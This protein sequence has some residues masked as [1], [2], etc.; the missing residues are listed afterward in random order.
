MIENNIAH[1]IGNVSDET[2][3]TFTT[4]TIRKKVRKMLILRPFLEIL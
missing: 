2:M 4:R 1:W 3:N